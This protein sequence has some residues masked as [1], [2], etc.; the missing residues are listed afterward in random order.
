MK[1]KGFGRNTFEDLHN[2]DTQKQ[3]AVHICGFDEI[4]RGNYYRGEPIGRAEVEVRVGKFKNGKAADKAE[5][6]G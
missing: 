5:I 1:C 4:Q 3:V 2:T 6:T